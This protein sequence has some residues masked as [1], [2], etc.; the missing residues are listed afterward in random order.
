MVA[1]AEALPAIRAKVAKDAALAGLPREKILAV[2][3]QLSIARFSV[4]VDRCRSWPRA[5]GARSLSL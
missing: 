2:V 1:F 3:T 4:L 5:A